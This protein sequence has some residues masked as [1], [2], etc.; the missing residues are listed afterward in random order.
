MLLRYLRFLWLSGRI[1]VLVFL[2]WQFPIIDISAYAKDTARFS[3]SPNQSTVSFGADGLVYW[4]PGGFWVLNRTT[5]EETLLYPYAP[6]LDYF[7]SYETALDRASNRIY[8]LEIEGEPYEFAN[9][10]RIMQI[11]LSTGNRSEIWSGSN[12]R[13]F[14]LSP[15]GTRMI[16]ESHLPLGENERIT[17][18]VIT[19]CILIIATGDCV[20]ITDTMPRNT[21]AY[22]LDDNTLLYRIQRLYLADIER[23]DWHPVPET[24]DW[25]FQDFVILPGRRLLSNA[26]RVSDN[27]RLYFVELNL[28]TLELTQLP[29]EPRFAGMNSL[30][31]NE[32]Y[33][34]Y[35]ARVCGPGS[36]EQALDVLDLQSGDYF[37]ITLTN[38]RC[39]IVWF[40]DSQ[41]ALAI[42]VPSTTGEIQQDDIVYI[43]LLTEEVRVLG[44]YLA[45]L[46]Q[47]VYILDQ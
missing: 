19:T 39:R 33:L 37:T 1:G 34:I 32:Q 46:Y 44:S 28:G 12:I 13:H 18:S 25:A 45:P 11:D 30:S 43:D 35:G 41:G 26:R 27:T 31:P 16:V 20:D 24:D 5:L 14:K 2:T 17:D 7:A 3:E 36:G 40:P 8:V 47:P 42:T 22:W 23:L 4:R 10:G 29:V 9:E 21:P 6:E 15:D 38:H